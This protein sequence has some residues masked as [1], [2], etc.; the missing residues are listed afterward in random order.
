LI[1]CS[2]SALLGTP[3]QPRSIFGCATRVFTA[4]GFAPGAA[5]ASFCGAATSSLFPCTFV[6]V[7]DFTA[8]ARFVE[9]CRSIVSRWIGRLEYLFTTV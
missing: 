5:F 8:V 2:S 1:F 6:S 7:P 4:C 9:A 3:F